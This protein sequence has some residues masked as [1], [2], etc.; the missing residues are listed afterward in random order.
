[1]QTGQD[2]TGQD[3]TQDIPSNRHLN[4]AKCDMAQKSM[5]KRDGVLESVDRDST[6]TVKATLVA[7]ACVFNM[8]DQQNR[9]E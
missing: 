1:M 3:S 2:R 6:A 4:A 7:I 9:I 5:T 8:T